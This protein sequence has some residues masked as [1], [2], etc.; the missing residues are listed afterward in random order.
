MKEEHN[1]LL[2]R[3][4]TEKKWFEAELD[5]RRG[6]VEYMRVQNRIIYTHTEVD[7]ALAGKGVASRL[8]N[9]ALEYARKEGLDIMP[10]CPFVAGYMK[11]NPAYNDL[12]A[13]G[14]KLG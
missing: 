14:F 4:N 10:L 13:P 7:K 6:R 8:V 11:K 12:L 1:E 5:G 9:F 2:L 3:N